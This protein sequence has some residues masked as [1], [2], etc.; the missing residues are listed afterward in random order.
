MALAPMWLNLKRSA[1]DPSARQ[2]TSIFN[3]SLRVRSPQRLLPVPP[4]NSM[5][6][7]WPNIFCPR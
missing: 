6:G 4:D 1:P 2:A 3:P 7:S 5:I